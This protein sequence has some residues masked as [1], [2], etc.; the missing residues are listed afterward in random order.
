MSRQFII[1]VPVFLL[2]V[3]CGR[4]Q[5]GRQ[6]SQGD[7][8]LAADAEVQQ[9]AG[10]FRFT[11]G[12][13]PDIR[14]N[15]YFTDIPNNRI[16]VWTL[17]DALTTFRENSGGANGL[18]FDS[19]GNLIACE[20]G[21]R[22]LVS[23]SPQGDVTVL[24]DT[25]QGNRFNSPNDLWVDADDGVY[26]SD[27]RYG[28][29]DNMEMGEHVYYLSPDR[30]RLIRVIDDMERPNGVIGTS[31]G[32]TLYV[33]DQGAGETYRYTINEDGT[34][35]DKTLFVSQ[36]SDGMTI[37]NQGNIYI[38]SG[39][40]EVYDPEGAHVLSIS[41]PESP[42]NLCFGGE[43]ADELYITARTSL[44]VVPMQVRG[45]QMLK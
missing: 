24:A 9:L 15:I 32:K 7:D 4:A 26:F 36:G 30:E 18:Y 41:I 28:N 20:G 13:A 23:I 42:A 29:R 14:G 34:L 19:Q 5:Q 35:S 31:D 12:P 38:T 44:Y 43:N 45:I 2:L 33:A 27:P 8:L 6:Q 37:D 40:V 22:R 21:N 25:Y 17:E 39:A 10:D 1:T 11:E 3:G 16:H